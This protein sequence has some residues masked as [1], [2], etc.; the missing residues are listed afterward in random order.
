MFFARLVDPERFSAVVLRRLPLREQMMTC[1]RLGW[2][3]CLNI[4][5]PDLHYKLRLDVPEECEVARMLCRVAMRVH[6]FDN[7][8][9]LTVNGVP[10]P[11]L[12]EDEKLWTVVSGNVQAGMVSHNVLE[13]D[14]VS[15]ARQRAVASAIIVQQLWRGRVRL[16][17]HRER[18]KK[19][20]LVSSTW[21][22]H[23]SGIKVM[24]SLFN[25]SSLRNV[26]D[27]QE[28][29]QMRQSQMRLVRAKT[30]GHL[31]AE[32]A[33][34]RRAKA[35]KKKANSKAKVAQDRSAALQGKSMTSRATLNTN[36]VIGNY[37]THLGRRVIVDGV[38]RT[39]H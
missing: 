1:R 31:R 9:K 26:F 34:E 27:K 23:V 2:L 18:W 10:K 36:T 3:A 5:F 22:A 11:N 17:Q 4:N 13:F 15:S 16:R 32:Q 19:G 21:M 37:S 20:L 6:G 14:F 7:L 25:Q 29:L 28:S 30:S 35:A 8:R 12:R 24:K 33:E 38:L 39:V